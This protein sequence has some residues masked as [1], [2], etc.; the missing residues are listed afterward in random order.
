[1]SVF[2]VDYIFKVANKPYPAAMAL[3][4][5]PHF[6][7]VTSRSC[8]SPERVLCAATF[9]SRTVFEPEGPVLNAPER[10]SIFPSDKG[11]V[12]GGGS[13]PFHLVSKPKDVNCLSEGHNLRKFCLTQFQWGETQFYEV[14][15]SDIDTNTDTN[16]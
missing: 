4:I 1:M 14:Q 9:A 16:T 15:V 2:L 7:P 6:A 11:T 10:A 8:F 3:H 13:P 5:K 12:L